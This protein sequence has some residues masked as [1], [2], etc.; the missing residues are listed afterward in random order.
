MGRRM[1]QEAVLP[2][3]ASHLTV[4]ANV[5]QAAVVH[6]AFSAIPFVMTNVTFGDRVPSDL[7][8]L[9]WCQ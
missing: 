6:G 8:R 1:Y 4:Q 5:L 3:V 9:G 2:H 7:A